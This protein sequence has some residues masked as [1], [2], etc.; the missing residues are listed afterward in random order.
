MAIADFNVE[1]AVNLFLSN[2][3]PKSKMNVGLAFYGRG[4]GNVPK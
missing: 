3:I 2:G 1:A 4:F